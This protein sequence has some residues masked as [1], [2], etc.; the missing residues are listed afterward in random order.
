MEPI[1]E[2]KSKPKEASKSPSKKQSKFNKL[3]EQVDESIREQWKEEQAKLKEDLIEEN[4]FDWYL[5]SKDSV[6][7][8]SEQEARGLSKLELIG[9]VDIR[10]SPPLTP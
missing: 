9:A 3:Q 8:N 2:S 6:E 5:P 10:Y 1:E 4:K 7:Y